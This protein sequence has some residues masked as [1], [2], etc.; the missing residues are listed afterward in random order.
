MNSM[1]QEN[2]KNTT[3]AIYDSNGIHYPCSICGKLHTDEL[4]SVLCCVE[5]CVEQTEN[6][7]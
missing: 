1:N 5:N 7:K 3:I 2:S 4:D 6:Q